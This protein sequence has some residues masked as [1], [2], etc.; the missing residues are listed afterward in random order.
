[1]RLERAA[2]NAPNGLQEF[3][4][5]AR[6]DGW[7]NDSDLPFLD[8]GITEFL[9]HHVDLSEGRNLPHG[10]V[11]AT[12]FWLLDDHENCVAMSN[13]RHSLTPLLLNRGGHIGYYVMPSERRKGYGRE[14]LARTLLEA[15]KLQLSRVLVSA[16]EDNIASL[17]IIEANGGVLDDKRTDAEG[18]NYRRYWID[19]AP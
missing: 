7:L 12:T 17:R 14:V 4:D 18:V 9:H 19:L 1:M 2:L 5:A 8:R 16:D 3:L 13:L 10:W 11:A 15:Q 6:T